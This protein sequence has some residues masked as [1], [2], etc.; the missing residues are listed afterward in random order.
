VEGDG[1]VGLGLVSGSCLG[2]EWESSDAK[3][4]GGES[5]PCAWVE[6]E[7]SIWAL[8]DGDGGGWRMWEGE[9]LDEAELARLIGFG[10]YGQW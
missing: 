5:A 2:V 8:M 4:H 3:G 6:S 9:V 10:N 7:E 1:A